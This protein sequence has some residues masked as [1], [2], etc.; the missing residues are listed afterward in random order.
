MSIPAHTASEDAVIAAVAAAIVEVARA[1]RTYD[2]LSPK[3]PTEIIRL[4]TARDD[5]DSYE[6][7]GVEPQGNTDVLLISIEEAAKR[8][9]VSRSVLYELLRTE[10]IRSVRVGRS[11]RIPA[12]ALAEFVDSLSMP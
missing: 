8:L 12:A 2:M 11:R 9:S 7:V 3:Q 1:L 4:A 5:A 6:P 10:R